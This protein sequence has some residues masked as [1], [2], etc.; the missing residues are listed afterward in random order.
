MINE[1]IF[2]QI[3]SYRDRLLWK[4]IEDCISKASNPELLT[5]GICWQHGPNDEWDSDKSRWETDSRIRILDIPSDQ[6][7]GCCWARNMI[8]KNLYRG[9]EYTLHLD[10]HM[11]FAHGW[12]HKL[13]HIFKSIQDNGIKKPII[14]TYGNSLHDDYLE[15]NIGCVLNHDMWQR[16]GALITTPIPW[17]RASEFNWKEHD[18]YKNLSAQEAFINYLYVPARFFSAHYA[19]TLGSHVLEVPHDPDMYFVG[20]EISLAVRSFTHGYDLFHPIENIIWH[21]WRTDFRDH[22]HWKEHK[23][24]WDQDQISKERLNVL[25]GYKVNNSIDFGEYGLGTIRSIKEYENF[26]QICFKDRAVVLDENNEKVVA[27]CKFDPESFHQTDDIEYVDLVVTNKEKDLL[28]I[29]LTPTTH[30]YLWSKDVSPP[31]FSG[32]EHIHVEFICSIGSGPFEF[33]LTPVSKSKGQMLK[34]TYPVVPGVCH[35]DGCAC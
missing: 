18:H 27:T 13:L 33:S 10:A 17:G 14:T 15:Y 22:E 21:Q 26:A 1:K 34:I 31:N 2:I 24:W 3:A 35:N 19:F 4:T 7:K 32:H 12:D 23:N 9:E 29:K 5:F 30:G 6:S 20:E 25:L 16:G 11:K 8:Q 28:N